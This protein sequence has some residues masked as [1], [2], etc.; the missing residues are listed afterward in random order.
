MRC[1]AQLIVL[2]ILVAALAACGG[3]A[4]RRC[5]PV[6]SF[7]SPVGECVALAEPPKPPMIPAKIEKPPP[8]PEPEPEPEP[9]KP[10]PEPEPPPTVVVTKEKIELDR[11]VQFESGKSKLIDDSTKLLDDVTKVLQEHPE[12]LL[13][14]IEGHTDS[15]GS[16]RK[17][18]KLSEAR[19]KAV[20]AYLI[21][22]G[23]DKKRL[24]AKGFGEA[25]PVEKNDTEEGRFKNRR[26]DLKILK[27]DDSAEEPKGEK[28]A[29]AADEKKDEKE[30]EGSGL[31]D[32][33]M[34][35]DEAAKKAAKK[36]KPKPK[37]KK[38]K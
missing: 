21:T 9:P 32:D 15:V 13:V 24:V 26:V 28:K 14:Q 33:D 37:K 2:A 25:K 31:I 12:I 16:D 4:N 20:R 10:E 22:H 36:K 30:D 27:R 18:K 5:T 7:S 35:D 19:A 3:K 34:I 11:T 38:K 8:E 17:N 23:I 29:D 6:P 1:R